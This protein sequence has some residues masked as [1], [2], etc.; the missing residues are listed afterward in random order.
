MLFKWVIFKF[1]VFSLHFV[2]RKKHLN[3]PFEKP[4]TLMKK[5]QRIVILHMVS[6]CILL[7]D[8][9]FNILCGIF[10]RLHWYG[11]VMVLLPGKVIWKA[12]R[13]AL[14]KFPLGQSSESLSALSS[15]GMWTVCMINS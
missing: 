10:S 9:H 4:E 3:T 2:S 8:H 6:A 15:F 14:Q 12:I 7:F 11:G 5:A 1:Y 13:V